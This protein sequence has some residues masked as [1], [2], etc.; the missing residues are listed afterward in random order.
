MVSTD[1]TLEVLLADSGGVL[2]V[3]EFTYPHP[4]SWTFRTIP[5]NIATATVRQLTAALTQRHT[6]P[7]SCMTNWQDRVGHTI[8]WDRVALII[9]SP[10]LTSR[11]YASYMKNV[12]HRTFLVRHID[13]NAPDP[14]CRCCRR[15]EE[16]TIHLFAYCTHTNRVW[17]RFIELLRPASIPGEQFFLFGL[18]DSH[19]MPPV[20]RALFVIVWKFILIA[21]TELGMHKTPFQPHLVWRNSLRR[22]ITKARACAFGAKLAVAQAIGRGETPDIS[23]KRRALAPLADLAESGALTWRPDL[24]IEISRLLIGAKHGSPSVADTVTLAA[25]LATGPAHIPPVRLY[26]PYPH[27]PDL[28]PRAR[29]APHLPQFAD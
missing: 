9:T 3:A 17:V 10:L 7:P 28:L 26:P 13:T 2:G 12:I 19:P 8:L 18:V 15:T 5:G 24:E 6:K 22:F 27:H 25:H 4:R 21:L 20:F 29:P 11:D 1:D 23:S 14:R 16:T